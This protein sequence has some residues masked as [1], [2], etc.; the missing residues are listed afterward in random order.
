MPITHGI[1]AGTTG[2]AE[3]WTLADGTPGQELMIYLAVDAGK[4]TLTPTTK[5]GFATIEFD[6]AGDQV[7][8]RFLPTLGWIIISAAGVAGPPAITV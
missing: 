5:T 4:G 8:L 2:G 1:V 6:D 7:V 3:A